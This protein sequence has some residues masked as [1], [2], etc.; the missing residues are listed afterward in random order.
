M[1]FIDIAPDPPLPA[2]LLIPTDTESV[3]PG[4][5]LSVAELLRY[6]FPNPFW[7]PSNSPCVLVWSDSQPTYV[8]AGLLLNSGVPR[9]E[10]L[11]LLLL[12]VRRLSPVPRSFNRSVI[13]S[14][15]GLPDCLPV[16]VLSFWN[17]L[18]EAYN[19]S[20]SWRRCLDWAN[21]QHSANQDCVSQELVRAT[22]PESPLDLYFFVYLGAAVHRPIDCW[23]IL[24]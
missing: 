17:H 15:E 20:L 7:T 16:W 10:T 23:G 1:D 3:L 14:C 5:H 22:L 9:Q 6:E 21:I 2:F 12:D 18:A 8:H 4:R 19:A 11:K 24:W 13:S